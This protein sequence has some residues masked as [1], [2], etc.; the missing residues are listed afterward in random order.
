MEAELMCPNCS[1]PSGA[2]PVR[3]LPN[4]V[5]HVAN[6]V[7]FFLLAR[8]FGA[9]PV[10]LQIL[11][12]CH[13]C[14]RTFTPAQSRAHTTACPECGYSLRGNLSGICP[15]CGKPVPPYMMPRLRVSNPD[16][17]HKG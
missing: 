8:S 12:R 6:G 4:L 14:Q 16:H 1:A 11:Y 10:R 7:A 5:K 13:L 17:F 9:P 15:E 3:T 2:R